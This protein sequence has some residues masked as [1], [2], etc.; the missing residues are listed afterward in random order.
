[1]EWILPV[2]VLAYLSYSHQRFEVLIG[3]VG[4]DVVEGAAISRI[5]IGCCK[6]YRHLRWKHVRSHSM[7]GHKQAH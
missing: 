1:M 7:D 5:S 6:I 3:L 4:V 2:I